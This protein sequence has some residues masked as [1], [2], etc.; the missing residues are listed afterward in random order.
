MEAAQLPLQHFGLQACT[1]H[2]RSHRKSTGGLA[3]PQRASVKHSVSPQW[4]VIA[5][6]DHRLCPTVQG[7]YVPT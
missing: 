1:E 4:C 7:D 6:Q 5:P 3:G 2:T